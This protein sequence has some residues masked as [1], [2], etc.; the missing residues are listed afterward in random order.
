[1]KWKVEEHHDGLDLRIPRTQEHHD[2]LEEQR[3]RK[4]GQEAHPTNLRTREN[5]RMRFMK[6]ARRHRDPRPGES[7]ARIRPSCVTYCNSP[8]NRRRHQPQGHYS[9][10]QGSG[11]ERRTPPGTIFGPKSDCGGITAKG[12]TIG[13][14][15]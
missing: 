12:P 5:L 13:G 11:W 7:S 15:T 6:G 3:S 9:P 10:E 2:G 4:K 14:A 1:M 8:G